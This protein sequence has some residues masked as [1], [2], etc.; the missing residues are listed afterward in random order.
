LIEYLNKM[1]NL[2]KKGAK[3]VLSILAH[4]LKNP[5]N[6]IIGFAELVEL[7]TD[8]IENPDIKRYL[9]IIKF[10]ASQ[11]LNL[12]NTVSAYLH[13]LEPEINLKEEKKIEQV[14]TQIRDKFHTIETGILSNKVLC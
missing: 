3:N 8:D 4:D 10:E 6:N 1:E 2:T 7:Q 5:L 9:D 14:L 11:A 13:E 12:I